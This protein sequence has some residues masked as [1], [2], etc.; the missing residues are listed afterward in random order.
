MAQV[1]SENSIT[2][3]VDTTRRHLLTVATAGAIAGLI[4][5]AAMPAAPAVDPIFAAIAECREARQVADI[6]YSRT[7]ALNREAKEKFGDGDTREMRLMH[8]EYI[9]GILGMDEDEYTDG[10]A[11][12]LYE[13]YDNFTLTEPISV[14][15]LFAML[16]YCEEVVEREPEVLDFVDWVP[17]LAA[18]AKSLSKRGLV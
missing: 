4:P 2:V 5:S 16:I 11:F 3:P 12:A 7:S 18:A 14:A 10:P 15:G 8:R 17:T 6:A 1:N 13:A 9:E